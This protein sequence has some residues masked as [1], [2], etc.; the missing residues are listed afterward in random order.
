MAMGNLISINDGE[1][2]LNIEPKS[3]HF[4]KKYP[5]FYKGIK[6]KRR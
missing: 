6:K 3:F 1:I 4:G 2:G 5:K